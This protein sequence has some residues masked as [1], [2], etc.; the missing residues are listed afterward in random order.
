MICLANETLNRLQYTLAQKLKV[1]MPPRK[2]E[3]ERARERKY[4]GE[5]R[6]KVNIPEKKQ[7]EAQKAHAGSLHERDQPKHEVVG[8]SWL[9]RWWHLRE[10]PTNR[11]VLGRRWLQHL[12]VGDWYG[13]GEGNRIC[14]LF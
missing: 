11:S 9:W 5:E 8:R 7:Q 6:K 2:R 12:P 4:I 13:F 1:E 14:G 3:R 10:A